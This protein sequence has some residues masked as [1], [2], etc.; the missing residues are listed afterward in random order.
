M[1]HLPSRDEFNENYN[2]LQLSRL[3]SS[4]TTAANRFDTYFSS[5]RVAE[6]EEAKRK[7]KRAI[8]K[9]YEISFDSDSE[10]D[11]ENVT[12]SQDSVKTDKESVSDTNP[13]PTIPT[14]IRIE[15]FYYYILNTKIATY[16]NAIGAF[17]DLIKDFKQVDDVSDM[18]IKNLNGLLQ[19]LTPKLN[20]T[21]QELI[22]PNSDITQLD[23]EITKIKIQIAL[24][25]I[26][27]LLQFLPGQEIDTISFFMG[28]LYEKSSMHFANDTRGGNNSKKTRKSGSRRLH[29]HH[30]IRSIKHRKSASRRLRRRGHN[31]KTRKSNREG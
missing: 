28:L 22:K 27:I 13:L 21:V 14:N 26:Y 3:T 9:Y 24:V 19:T 1:E 25:A 4:S 5:T 20:D 11:A 30:H 29:R 15:D 2:K 17:D 31:V 18:I 12:S 23:N 10:S 16:T 7:N 6:H 8:Q